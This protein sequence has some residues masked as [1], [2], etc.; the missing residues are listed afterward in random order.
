MHEHVSCGEVQ[1]NTVDTTPTTLPESGT[2]VWGHT[3]PPV[4]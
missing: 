1:A 4:T 3:V 2:Q